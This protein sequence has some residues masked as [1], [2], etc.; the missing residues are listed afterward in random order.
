MDAVTGI[1]AARSEKIK[2][3]LFLKWIVSVRM[4]FLLHKLNW[5]VIKQDNTYQFHTA[6]SC[7][8]SLWPTDLS[9]DWLIYI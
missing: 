8:N 9:G 4:K 2:N 1:L 6:T 3:N 5:K 7:L